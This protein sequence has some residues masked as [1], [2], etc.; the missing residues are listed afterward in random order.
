MTTRLFDCSQSTN[1]W[2]LA[3]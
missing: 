2:F 3:E 1:S